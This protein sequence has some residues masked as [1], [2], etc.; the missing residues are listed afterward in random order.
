M[1]EKVPLRGIQLALKALYQLLTLAWLTWVALPR[2]KHIL[3]QIPPAIPTMMV[4]RAAAL[5]HRSQLLFDWHNFAY[6]I[7]ALSLGN[8]H[9]L[10]RNYCCCY[11][12]FVLLMLTGLFFL[13]LHNSKSQPSAG[14]AG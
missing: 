9:W 4:L 6:T 11:Y 5:I 10:V 1:V 12:Y 13:S 3:L 7:M 8:S 14:N 2:S